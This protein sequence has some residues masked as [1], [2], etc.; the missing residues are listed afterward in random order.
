MRRQ[1][2]RGQVVPIFKKQRSCLVSLQACT[3]S[4]HWAREIT[5][6]GHEVR[7]MAPRYVKSY[8]KR[9]KNDMADAE[10]IWEGVTRPT[11][12][13]GSSFAPCPTIP[14]T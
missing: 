3:I 11:M 2:S 4:Q 10:A 13:S 9:N 12:R 7:L 5:V 6:L 1:L 14:P 8:V